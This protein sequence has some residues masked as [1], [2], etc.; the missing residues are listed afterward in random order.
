VNDRDLYT[1]VCEHGAPMALPCGKCEEYEAPELED[2]EEGAALRKL[3]LER[4]A[5]RAELARVTEMLKE[6]RRCLFYAIKPYCAN[7]CDPDINGL[8]VIHEA[9]CHDNRDAVAMID[10]ALSPAT[11]EGEP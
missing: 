3:I 6:A 11:E 7:R 8:V 4:D 10:R 9:G 1:N 2:S 5:A